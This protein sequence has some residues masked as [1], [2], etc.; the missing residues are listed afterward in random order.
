MTSVV[1]AFRSSGDARIYRIPL[2][3]FPILSGYVHLVFADDVIALIDVGSGFGDANDQLEV[4]M[5]EVRS[6]YGEKA[7]WEDLT[8]V[9]ITHGHID[10]FGGLHYV[11]E[12]T[13]AKVGIHDLDLRVLANYEERLKIVEHRLRVFLV[14]AGVDAVEGQGIMN[15]Y[16]LNKYLFSS[17]SPDFTY[18]AVGMRVGPLRM[19]HVP[20]HCPGQVVIQLDDVLFSADHVLAETS[21]H[22]APERLSLNTGLGHYLESLKRLRPLAGAI[23][24]TLG[25]H[26]GPI[27]DLAGRISE[28]EQLHQ[29]RLE[30][31]LNLLDEPKTIAEISQSLFPDADGYHKLL[32]L[33]EAGAHVEYLTLRGYLE[34]D[35]LDQLDFDTPAPVRYSRLEGADRLRSAFNAETPG[36]ALALDG[37]S[38]SI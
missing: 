32:A 17:L 13:Q 23:R 19:V 6:E 27:E 30:Q 16:L 26:E 11:R 14:E 7:N 28:I 12:R 21:P 8:H 3:L 5:A 25:G 15:L 10:H 31:V 29:E 36:G 35:N 24:L 20:G 18:E 2:N 22:Q 1:E 37:V 4:G 38:A 34:I 9:L 33:E